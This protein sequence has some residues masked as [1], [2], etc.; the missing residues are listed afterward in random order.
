MKYWR[1]QEDGVLITRGKNGRGVCPVTV[2]EGMLLTKKELTRL[3]TKGFR[4]Y[5]HRGVPLEPIEISSHKTYISF[6]CRFEKE[7]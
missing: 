6:G 4:G 3:G 2:D 5:K 7:E 1:V